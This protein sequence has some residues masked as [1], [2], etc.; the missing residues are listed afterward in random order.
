[1]FFLYVVHTLESG[2]QL[3]PLMVL[4]AVREATFAMSMCLLGPH[5]GCYTCGPKP[6]S[7]MFAGLEMAV[8]I[9]STLSPVI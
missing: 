7:K 1:M 5:G 4:R 9:G 3:S 2:R 8:A 6:S